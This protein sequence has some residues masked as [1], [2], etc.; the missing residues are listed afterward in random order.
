MSNTLSIDGFHFLTTWPWGFRK[1]QLEWS[2]CYRHSYKI[3]SNWLSIANTNGSTWLLV[4]YLTCNFYYWLAI[5]TGRFG[6]GINDSSYILVFIN[7][8]WPNDAIRQYIPWSTLV[9]VMACFLN[10]EKILTYNQRCFMAF[11]CLL[12]ELTLEWQHG[13]REIG[14]H[15]GGNEHRD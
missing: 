11:T 9:Q 5:F 8:L 15:L 2:Q 6:N 4:R 12:T 14:M 7:S 3:I 1:F 10:L 13:W